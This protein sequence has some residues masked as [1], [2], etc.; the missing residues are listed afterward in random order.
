MIPEGIYW[1]GNML[2][3]VSIAPALNT[4]NLL[5]EKFQHAIRGFL[6]S[7]TENC[8]HNRTQQ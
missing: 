7:E 3:N 5:N 8:V 2:Q 1:Q 6:H 4:K